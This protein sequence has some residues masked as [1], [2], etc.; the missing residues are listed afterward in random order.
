[1][2]VLAHAFLGLLLGLVFLEITGDRRAVPV[3]VAGALLPDLLDK[4]LALFIP[5]L[6]S[7]RT[8]GHCLLFILVMSCIALFLCYYRQT[9]LGVAFVSGILLH[10]IFD[11]MW[12]TTQTWLYPF[13]G[14]FPLMT[15]PDYTGYY[16]LLEL[17]S[18]SEWVFFAAS[19]LIIAGV[20][21]TNPPRPLY[22]YIMAGILFVMGVFLV[23]AGWS[24]P[25]GSFFAPSYS[26]TPSALTGLLAMV[27]AIFLIALTE[28]NKKRLEIK[29]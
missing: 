13:S 8:V 12:Q 16:L 28:R 20:F 17:M 3:S 9:I 18:P 1:M 25:G 10:Q 22:Y 2:F 19:I 11:S 26:A 29:E 24:G 27:G 4:P 23:A 6:G 21:A 15:A 7:G 14:Q 5:V